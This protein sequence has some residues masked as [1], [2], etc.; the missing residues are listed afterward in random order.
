MECSVCKAPQ[1][2]HDLQTVGTQIQKMK[3]EGAVSAKKHLLV[4]PAVMEPEHVTLLS[5]VSFP[6]GLRG[7]C[8]PSSWFCFECLIPTAWRSF[9]ELW[10]QDTSSLPILLCHTISLHER[11]AAGEAPSPRD[12]KVL[13]AHQLPPSCQALSQPQSMLCQ[14]SFFLSELSD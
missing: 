8:Q 6:G 11:G 1:H 5:V 14:M 7:G 10:G 4:T 2:S 9:T 12:G 13:H 3:P